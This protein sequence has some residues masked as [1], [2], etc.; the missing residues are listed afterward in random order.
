ML[1]QGLG[2]HGVWFYYSV[3]ASPH[4]LT[5]FFSSPQ[6]HYIVPNP[7]SS[8]PFQ[9]RPAVENTDLCVSVVYS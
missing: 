9:A 4:I 1:F 8:E 5:I 2:Q 3:T 7:S 6:E